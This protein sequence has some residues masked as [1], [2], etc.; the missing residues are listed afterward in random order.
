MNGKRVRK[1]TRVHLMI[2]K[3]V[4]VVLYLAASV[5]VCLFI[6][7]CNGFPQLQHVFK[8]WGGLPSCPKFATVS[9]CVFLCLSLSVRV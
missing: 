4:C 1:T 8:V 6:L 5:R 7:T 3:S 2:Y 9:V